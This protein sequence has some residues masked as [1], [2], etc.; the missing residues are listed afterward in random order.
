MK[1]TNHRV[2]GAEW[3]PA[4]SFSPSLIK[5]ELI[6]LHDTA[7]RLDKH[8]SAKWFQ[9]PDC[10]ASAHVIIERDGSITQCVPFNQRA[11]HAGRSTWKGRADCN[12]WSIGIEM[13]NPGQ[14]DKDGRAWF[15]R[16]AKDPT[17]WQRGFPV[18]SLKKALVPNTSNEFAWWLEYTSEQIATVTNL[19]RTL[20][21]VYEIT[22]E[23]GYL[24]THWAIAPKRKVDTCPLF[25]LEQVR[26][27]VTYKRPVLVSAVGHGTVGTAAGA[28]ARTVVDAETGDEAL[29]GLAPVTPEGY[30]PKPEGWLS[31]RK[32][33]QLN[34]MAEQG[35][36]TASH[37]QSLKA[38]LWRLLGVG[39]AAGGTIGLMGDPTKG[40]APSWAAQH[41]ILLAFVCVLVTL[42]VVGG[43]AWFFAKRVEKALVKAWQ[44]GLHQ[45][46]QAP[47]A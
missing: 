30:E 40:A 31:G 10:S 4:R 7:G 46:S 11:F 5:P 29:P 25:P 41:P 12:G 38:W 26:R 39:S 9:D 27:A 24:T 44:K 2:Y 43:L 15:H 21:G 3:L 19:C 20:V 8:S 32:F 35:S 18:A 6:V 47:G 1:I 42:I 28:V 13:V 34:D 45:P 33:A 22:D 14:L 36:Q 23:Y 16:L 17:K 37:L